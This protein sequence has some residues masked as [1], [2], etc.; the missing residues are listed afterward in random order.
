LRERAEQG[1]RC[2]KADP[3]ARCDVGHDA[4]ALRASGSALLII[5]GGRGRGSAASRE[6]AASA[7][8][9]ICGLVG[10]R[11]PGID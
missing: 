3:M 7:Q 2:V 8:A 4:E 5:P 10:A 6:D 11:V 9:S 1:D